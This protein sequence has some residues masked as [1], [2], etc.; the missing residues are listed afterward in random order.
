MFIRKP[1]WIAAHIWWLFE[2]NKKVENTAIF[3]MHSA[4]YLAAFRG[5]KKVKIPQFYHG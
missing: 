3:I 4:A 2:G 1:S 5:N